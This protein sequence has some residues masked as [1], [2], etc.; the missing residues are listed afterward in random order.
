MELDILTTIN[1]IMEF[2]HPYKWSYITFIEGFICWKISIPRYF[3]LG[4]LFSLLVLRILLEGKTRPQ[5]QD[6][7]FCTSNQRICCNTRLPN[8]QT[9]GR[10][11]PKILPKNLVSRYLED[12]VISS[13]SGSWTKGN[14]KLYKSWTLGKCV[15]SYNIWKTRIDRV[16]NKIKRISQIQQRCRDSEVND[17]KVKLQVLCLFGGW[18]NIFQQ[19]LN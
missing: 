17:D 19:C 16:V 8:T 14:N 18:K 11:Y 6:V 10:Y 2:V 4:V 5:R 9:W 1:G 15:I 13:T 12:Y 7:S 3:L